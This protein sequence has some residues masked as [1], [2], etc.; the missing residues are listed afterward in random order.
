MRLQRSCRAW[1]P[2]W[3]CPEHGC[4]AATWPRRLGWSGLGVPIDIAVYARLNASW[5]TL[6]AQLIAEVD[7]GYGVYNGLTFKGDRFAA[8]LKRAGIP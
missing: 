4:G 6:K 1:L 8:Y 5:S 7:Q 2:N 3:T